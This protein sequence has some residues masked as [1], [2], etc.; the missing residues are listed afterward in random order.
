MKSGLAK[1]GG[2]LRSELAFRRLAF[3]ARRK[4]FGAR[5]FLGLADRVFEIAPGETFAIAPIVAL[6]GQADKI[7]QIEPSVDPALEW[8]RFAGGSYDVRPLRAYEFSN[9]MLLDG[10]LYCGASE[11]RIRPN[12]ARAGAVGD[13]GVLDIGEGAMAGSYYGLLFFGHWLKDDAPLHLLASEYGV[14]VSPQPP[15]WPHLPEY[16]GMMGLDFT[17][18]EAARF[19]KLTVFA[20]EEYTSHKARRI[21]VLR[22]RLIGAPVARDRRVFIRRG[23]DDEGARRFHNEEAVVEALA[24]DGFDI[25]DPT[26]ATV[27]EIG[28]VM[29]RADLVVGIEG[30]QL[31][32]ATYFLDA[33]CKV[34]AITPPARYYAGHKRWTDH[35]GA[36]YGVVMGDPYTDEGFTANIDDVRRTVDL[37]KPRVTA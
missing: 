29:L 11:Q 19:R 28:K 26:S 4:L 30:S 36:Q 24:K 21:D 1:S 15:A 17:P 25:I 6:P 2:L 37:F 18:T 35:L 32:H 16:A 5:D 22:R 20:D 23:S 10:A 34:L 13:A 14:A 12:E 31:S 8:R 9:V 33:G 27:E 3:R 7:I